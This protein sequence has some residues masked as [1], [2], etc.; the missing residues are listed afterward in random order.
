MAQPFEDWY[1]NLPIVT[2]IYMTGCVVTSVSVYLGLVGPLRLYLNFPLVF[3]KYEFWRLFT[4]FFFYDEIGMNFFFHMYFLVRHSRLLEESSFRGRSADYLYMW[5]FGS[6]LLLIMDAFL[7]YTK[8]VTK[9]LFLAPSIAFMVIYVW[10]RR[11]PNM[12]ISFLGIFTFSAPYL[13][14]VILIM[15]YLFNHDLATDLL[16]AVAGHC[17]YF[18]EDIYPLI[19][20]RRLLKT[21]TFL[22]SLMDGQQPIVDAHQQEQQNEQPQQPQEV[23]NVLNEDDLDQQ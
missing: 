13:P 22:K 1:K 10:S 21:P 2:K 4:N 19:S 7:F 18:L 11:N 12:H 3:G 6:F 8:I 23:Q 5:I 20:N 9:V 17:Y 14:W 15:G 16:G